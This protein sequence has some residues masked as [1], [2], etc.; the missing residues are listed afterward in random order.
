MGRILGYLAVA[1]TFVL[2]VAQLFLPSEGI[3]FVTGLV[4]FLITWW[5]VLF[6]TLPLGVRSQA[7]QGE[8]VEGTEP[9]AP[10]L[11]DLKKK[12]WLT[13]VIASCVW[14]V[15]FVLIEFQPIPLDAIP[16]LP[17]P[18]GFDSY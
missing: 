17:N 13:T 1:L 4:V 16:F 10:V 8:V 2:W 5:I 11:P 15:L 14:L 3:G 7:E 12:A 18:E 9:G 6:M